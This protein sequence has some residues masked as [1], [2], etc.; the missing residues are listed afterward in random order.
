LFA[1]GDGTIPD[2]PTVTVPPESGRGTVIRLRAE[3]DA[4]D[5]AMSS[6]VLRTPTPVLDPVIRHLSRASDYKALW[7]ATSAAVAM[8]DGRRGRRAAVRCLAAIGATSVLVDLVGKLAFPRER[9]DA[10]PVA[11][12]RIAR[13]P[14]SS[15]FP[16]GHAATASAF[17]TAFRQEY[18]LLGLPVSALAA[19][20]SYGRVHT[21][22]HYPSDVIVGALVGSGAASLTGPLVERAG[23]PGQRGTR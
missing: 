23:R 14:T 7:F 20:V 15:S 5:Q 12:D 22:V 13:R 2:R 21:G 3:V 10:D 17:A 18:P 19:V 4:L 11:A 8:F 6:A 16:S 1:S 9:P